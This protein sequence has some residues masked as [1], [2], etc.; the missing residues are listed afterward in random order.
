[1]STVA[2]AA[3]APEPEHPHPEIDYT[4]RK[5]ISSCTRCFATVIWVITERGQKL[6]IDRQ[7]AIASYDPAN[8][9]HAWDRGFCV[10][11]DRATVHFLK[12]TEPP[13]PGVQV[14]RSHFAT[15]PFA[16]GF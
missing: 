14:F 13:R 2:V 15:C 4:A 9:A 6:P 16:G 12:K 3:P 5:R 1:M 10:F 7:P 11:T 8:P